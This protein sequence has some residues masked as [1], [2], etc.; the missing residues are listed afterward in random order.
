[1]N[2]PEL[3]RFLEANGLPIDGGVVEA[4]G[5]GDADS[6]V[7][8]AEVA[9]ARDYTDLTIVLLILAVEAGAKHRR[10]SIASLYRLQGNEEMAQKW[11]VLAA[12]DGDVEAMREYGNV[13]DAKGDTEEA[14]LWW[15]KAAKGGDVNAMLILAGKAAADASIYNTSVPE[16][17]RWLTMAAEAGSVEAMRRLGNVNRHQGFHHDAVRWLTM[18]V[19]AGHADAQSDLDRAVAEATRDRGFRGW[20]RRN[21]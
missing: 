10:V 18:A 8:I 14:D 5:N 16:G 12:N 6:L 1:M 7:R 2:Y 21:F 3:R 15:R 11:M 20:M 13:Q 9:A 19:K 4:A 17:R